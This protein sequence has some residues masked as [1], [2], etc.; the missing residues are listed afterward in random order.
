MVSPSFM[1]VIPTQREV[2]LYYGRT[3]SNNLGQAFTLVGWLLVV[4]ILVVD[5]RPRVKVA[6]APQARARVP[7]RPRGI[8]AARGAG[9]LRRRLR[10]TGAGAGETRWSPPGGFYCAMSWS[11]TRRVRGPSNSAR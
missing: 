10:R 6:R 9:R 2:T 7:R 8:G 4:V 3:F 1:M 5:L 11:R